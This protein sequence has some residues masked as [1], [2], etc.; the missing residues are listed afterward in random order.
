[1]TSV[2][3]ISPSDKNDN[4][5]QDEIPTKAQ[6]LCSALGIYCVETSTLRRD[7]IL[8]MPNPFADKHPH[9]EETQGEIGSV[10]FYS[11]E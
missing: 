8:T 3:E 2:N 11:F 4:R 6:P 10:F 9:K 1:M 5:A 7:E